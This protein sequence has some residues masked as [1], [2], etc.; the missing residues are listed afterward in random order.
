MVHCVRTSWLTRCLAPVLLGLLAPLSALAVPTVM[1][2]DTLTWIPAGNTNL[3]ETYAIGN[4][5]VTVTFTGNTVDSSFKQRLHRG[6]T[7]VGTMITLPSPDVTSV[8]E[9][10]TL[11]PPLEAEW[12]V[13]SMGVAY[14]ESRDRVALWAEQLV[15]GGVEL[16][17]SLRTAGNSPLREASWERR[18]TDSL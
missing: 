12:A 11:Q 6:P 13:A 1:D 15:L 4:G 9:Q 14:V 16:A 5:N 2:W 17:R 18:W 10:A 8:P 7:L 3:S